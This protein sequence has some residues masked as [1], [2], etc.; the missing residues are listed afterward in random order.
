MEYYSVRGIDESVPSFMHNLMT[1]RAYNLDIYCSSSFE[2][3]KHF[4]RHAKRI[5]LQMQ[6]PDNFNNEYLISYKKCK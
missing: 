3:R 4:K 2:I 1:L 6:Q 5:I